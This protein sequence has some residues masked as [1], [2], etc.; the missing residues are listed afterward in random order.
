MPLNA[1][2]FRHSRGPTKANACDSTRE[3]GPN[4]QVV[5]NPPVLDFGEPRSRDRREEVKSALGR[6]SL[7]PHAIGVVAELTFGADQRNERLPQA[8]HL[9]ESRRG[10]VLWQSR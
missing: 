9:H 6:V 4:G 5:T 1:E 3:S 8:G 2:Y 10:K 7:A